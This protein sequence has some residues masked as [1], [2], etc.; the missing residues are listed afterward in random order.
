[1]IANEIANVIIISV[2][3]NVIASKSKIVIVTVKFTVASS[4]VTQ[5]HFL[6]F[7]INL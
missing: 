5:L 4:A 1:M 3:G 7:V 2:T 6:F